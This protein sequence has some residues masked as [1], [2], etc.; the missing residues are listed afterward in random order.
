M[1]LRSLEP[2]RGR[3]SKDEETLLR[4]WLGG[5]VA[6]DEVRV[7]FQSREVGGADKFRWS[8]GFLKKKKVGALKL[9]AIH[10]QHSI[11]NLLKEIKVHDTQLWIQKQRHQ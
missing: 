1:M 11:G 2:S 3:A 10:L 8:V 9:P 6:V 4:I 7:E 5:R